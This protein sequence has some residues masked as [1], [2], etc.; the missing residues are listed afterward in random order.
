MS[1][2]E[3]YQDLTRSDFVER[4]SLQ[5]CPTTRDINGPILD[6]DVA[7]AL[8]RLDGN[9]GAVAQQLGR[10]RRTIDTYISRNPQ[11]QELQEDIYEAFVDDAEAQ[12]RKLARAGD[13][14]M[15]KFVLSTIGKRRGYVTR[16]EATGK[17]GA[18]LGVQFFLP[19]N[20][21]ETVGVENG[22]HDIVPEIGHTPDGGTGESGESADP[23]HRVDAGP[24]SVETGSE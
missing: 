12:A 23:R 18:P 17:D 15:V 19:L 10:S 5:S 1:I 24:V 3:T 11:L 14:G 16:V 20:G 7:V 9:I 4:Y 13:G 2:F 22:A 6:L 8:L 21:R